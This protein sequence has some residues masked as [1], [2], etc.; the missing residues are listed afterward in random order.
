MSANISFDKAKEL[1]SGFTGQAEQLLKD[2]SKVEELLQKLEAKMK[3][4]P[5][6]GNALSKLP[7]MISMIRGYITREYTVVSPKVII[8][9][10]CDAIYLLKGQDVIPD[11]TPV[12]GYV[13]DLAIV[14]AAFMLSEPELNAYA[15]WREENGKT[16]AEA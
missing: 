5:A 12:V 14:S 10:L 4:I 8:T 16:T 15:Q 13:D 3:E 11:S 2:T 9:L 7:L 6:V 1:L